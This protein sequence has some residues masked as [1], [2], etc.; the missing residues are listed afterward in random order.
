MAYHNTIRPEMGA[1]LYQLKIGTP[2]HFR[3]QCQAKH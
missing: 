1:R 2:L 3:A